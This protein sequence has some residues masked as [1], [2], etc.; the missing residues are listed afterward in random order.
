[1]TFLV[2]ILIKTRKYIVFE[3]FQSIYAGPRCRKCVLPVLPNIGLV[4]FRLHFLKLSYTVNERAVPFDYKYIQHMMG[5]YLFFD[6]G[7][8]LDNYGYSYLVRLRQR[9]GKVI[10]MKKNRLR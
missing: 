1:M 7:P 6:L 9:V 8:F 3:F 2:R 10:P 4:D 5:K